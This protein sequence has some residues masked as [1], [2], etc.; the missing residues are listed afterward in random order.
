MSEWIAGEAIAEAVNAANLFRKKYG[1]DLI[2][3]L[4]QSKAGDSD[5]CVLARAF[6]FDCEVDGL[7]NYQ[8]NNYNPELNNTWFAKFSARD[9]D[10]AEALAK[11]LNTEVVSENSDEY[12]ER[13]NSLNRVC[14][15]LPKKIAEIAV[16]F[17]NG[18]LDGKYY[19]V[20]NEGNPISANL[21]HT[22]LYE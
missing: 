8:G 18:N 5:K 2:D 15:I 21:N 6:N 17:D 10:K 3:D 14:V 1:H 19:T 7:N 9:K 13:N 16:Q 4:P 22:S 20:D 12:K 11:I